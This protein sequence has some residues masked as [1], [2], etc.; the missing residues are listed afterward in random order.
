MPGEWVSWHRNLSELI[1]EPRCFFFALTLD[2]DIADMFVVDM[3]YILVCLDGLE[4]L[5]IAM[6]CFL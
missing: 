2:V 4:F 6:E 3:V 5:K 1:P